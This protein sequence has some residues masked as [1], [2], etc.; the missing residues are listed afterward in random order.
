MLTEKT[1]DA[2][3]RRALFVGADAYKAAGG[4]IIRDLFDEDDGGWLQDAPLLERLVGEKLSTA[5]E[6]IKAEGWAWVETAVDFPWNHQRA[7]RA[8]KAIAP[9]LSDDEDEKLQSLFNELETLD[10]TGDRTEEEDARREKVLRDIA[11]LENR[12]PVFDEAQKAKAGAFVSLRDDGALLIER[13]YVR[14][15]DEADEIREKVH[16]VA[17]TGEHNGLEAD[18]ANFN[19]A[20]EAEG[21][22]APAAADEDDDTALPDRLMME[23]TAYHSL[24]LRDALAN[25][26]GIAFLAMLHAMTLRLFYHYTSD[27]CLQI[28]ATDSLVSPFP[29]LADF[30]AS[31]AIAARHRAW[32]EALP[33]KPEELWAALQSFDTENR[34]AL[35]AHCAGL[36]VNA[37]HEP[38]MRFFA[39]T[40][41]RPAPRRIAPARHGEGRLGDA[42]RQ[43]PEPGHQGPDCRRGPGGEGRQ[44]GRASCRSQEKRD[45]V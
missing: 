39:K 33:E 18:A 27:T 14:R 24:A 2:G 37:V 32:E 10:E 26:P 42:R 9:A 23:L 31:T 22:A 44:D 16:V 45:G 19:G 12:S 7:Y 15:E 25:N 8:L 41:P 29:G 17:V 13:G 35:F 30:A 38:A 40:P 28:E 1:V 3:D 6:A 20:A 21:G 34:E 5:A 43:L 4:I 11:D 36:T